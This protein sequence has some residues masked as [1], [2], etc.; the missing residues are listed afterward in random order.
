V[1]TVTCRLCGR[2]IA[3]SPATHLWWAT[4]GSEPDCPHEPWEADSEDDGEPVRIIVCTGV[5]YTCDG[6]DPADWLPGRVPPDLSLFRSLFRS[7][8]DQ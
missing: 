6:F 1:N 7:R 3:L 4:D 8:E 2:P 5:P